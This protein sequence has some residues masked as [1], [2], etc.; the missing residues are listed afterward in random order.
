MAE[1]R[2]ALVGIVVEDMEATE[3]INRILH[4]YSGF[5][6]GRMGIPYRP[7]RV[8]IISVVVDAPNDVIS[9]LSGKLGMIDGISV[10]TVYSKQ[11]QQ[12]Q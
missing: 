3:K 8:C 5:I 2:I 1:T 10:K 4:E 12:Q 7:Q 6:V 9:S 11:A